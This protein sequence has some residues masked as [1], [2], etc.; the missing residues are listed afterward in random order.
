M[1]DYILGTNS[2]LLTLSTFSLL[3]IGTGVTVNV[4]QGSGFSAGT[5]YVL[6]RYG[7]IADNSRN[8]SGWTANGGPSG[9]TA[10]FS[11]DPVNGNLDVKFTPTNNNLASYSGGPGGPFGTAAATSVSTSSPGNGYA[12]ITSS[13]TSETSSTPAANGF[14]PLLTDDGTPQHNMLNGEILAGSNSGNFTGNGAATVSIAWRNRT[15]QETTIPEGGSPSS[16]PL[17]AASSALI[18]NVLNL[19]SMSTSGGE[20]VQTDPF[21]L[22]MNYDAALLYNEATEAASGAIYL[23]WL[24]PN[25]GGVPLWQNAITGDTGGLTTPGTPIYLGSFLNYVNS[26]DNNADFPLFTTTY[27]TATLGN[28]TNAQLEE[29]LGDWGVDTANHDVWAVIDHNSAFAVAVVPEPATLTLAVCGFV[30]LLG[31]GFRRRR[32]ALALRLS[33]A[34]AKARIGNSNMRTT[35]AP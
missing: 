1:L 13:V 24:N 10:T 5:T 21:V 8:F 7:A 30:S 28:L 14:G 29:I 26:L 33:M 34:A 20:P 6:I 2:D 35:R 4:T 22:Q 23:A 11:L 27:T 16:P 18:S 32:R 25:G 12:G 3:T 19:T 31:Y 9:D 17:P 15:L